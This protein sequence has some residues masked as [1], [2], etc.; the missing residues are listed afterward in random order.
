MASKLPSFYS[1][2]STSLSETV[3]FL[4]SQFDTNSEEA[5]Q[6]QRRLDYRLLQYKLKRKDSSF[7]PHFQVAAF[8]IDIDFPREETTYF[9]LS[10]INCTI[11]WIRHRPCVKRLYHG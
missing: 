7:Q 5:C 10:Q 11:P 9:M 1:E 3:L 2:E 4:Y 8:S 6:E